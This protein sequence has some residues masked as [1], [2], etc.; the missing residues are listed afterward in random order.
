MPFNNVGTKTICTNR[1]IL[2]PILP[3]D[4]K[5]MY[6]NWASDMKLAKFLRWIPHASPDATS[7]YLSSFDYGDA[8]FYNW[9]IV[10]GN[11]LVG[12]ISVVRLDE[13]L[14]VAEIGY[15]AGSRWWNRGIVTEALGGVKDF[16]FGEVGI[17]KLVLRHDTENPA[18]GRVMQKNGMT[19]E[20]TLREESAGRRDGKLGDVAYYGLLRSEWLARK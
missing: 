19:L 13:K 14:G 1:L 17:N 5:E 12:N 7:E 3:S 6:K 4:A 9:G 10:F 20:G 18:S 15:C 11:E 16:L 8:A 2:R